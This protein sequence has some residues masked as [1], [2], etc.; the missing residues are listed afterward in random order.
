MFFSNFKLLFFCHV[1]WN[2]APSIVQPQYDL[3]ALFSFVS[4]IC[5]NIPHLQ[6]NFSCSQAVHRQSIMFEQAK[7]CHSQQEWEFMFLSGICITK[8]LCTLKLL[9]KP[10]WES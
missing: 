8:Y 4:L 5:Q 1:S 3:P 2:L 9:Q 6:R 10:K 7:G